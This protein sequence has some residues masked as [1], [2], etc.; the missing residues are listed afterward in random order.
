MKLTCWLGLGVSHLAPFGSAHTCD[1]DAQMHDDDGLDDEAFDNHLDTLYL[2]QSDDQTCFRDVDDATPVTFADDDLEGFAPYLP[3]SGW[4]IST[5][6]FPDS[7]SILPL[8]TSM[9]S[10]SSNIPMSFGPDI[11]MSVRSKSPIVG[12]G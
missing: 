6:I 9:S 11:P 2:K 12:A 4:R 10:V 5:D 7:F 3:D 1:E 8:S